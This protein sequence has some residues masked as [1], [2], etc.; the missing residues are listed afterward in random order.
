MNKLM[1]LGAAVAVV[2]AI[3]SA[4]AP[5]ARAAAVEIQLMGWSSSPSENAR[6]QEIVD[7]FNK[8]NPD[9]KVSLNQVPDYDTT[10]A[11]ALSAGEPP[12]VFYVDSFRFR[13]LVQAGALASIGDKLTDTKDFYPSLAAAFTADEKLYCPPKDF[14]TLALQINTDML[15]EAGIKVAPKTWDELYAAAKAMTKGDRV[16]L[17][18]PADAARFI[19]FVYGAGAE[20]TD[21][22]FTKMTINTPEGKAALDFYTKLLIDGVGKTPAQLGAGWPGEAFSKGQAAMAF[23]GNWIVPF[24]KDQAP[25]LNYTVAEL[26]VGPSGKPATMAFTVC[27]GVAAASKNQDAAIKFV[28]YITGAE[29]MKAWTDLG[30]AMPT[31]ESLREGWSKAF[32]P[33]KAFLDGAAYARKWAFVPGWNAVNDKVAEQI[34]K[35]VDGEVTTEDALASIETTGNEVLKKAASMVATAEATAA[36]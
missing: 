28:D 21:A 18:V 32:E 11:K 7:G 22:N 26:P 6:L 2:A 27:Y 23:E 1:R 20:M 4:V 29:G 30:L 8:A 36:K 3:S 15:K 19:A 5:V 16:G 31:R 10:L 17:V 25:K 35:V 33:Q 13:D 9:I 14:S 34:Q 12:D 24:L